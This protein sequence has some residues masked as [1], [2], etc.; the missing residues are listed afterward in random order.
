M[1]SSGIV[2]WRQLEAYKWGVV[3]LSWVTRTFDSKKC[4]LR[5]NCALYQKAEFLLGLP[6]SRDIWLYQRHQK[7]WAYSA[8]F[9]FPSQRKRQASTL[10][11]WTTAVFTLLKQSLPTISSLVIVSSKFWFQRTSWRPR[12]NLRCA[13]QR[14]RTRCLGQSDFFNGGLDSSLFWIFTLLS[15]KHFW[16]DFL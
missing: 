12:L 15:A 11:G 2:N 4:D 3:K 7:H 6:Q 14:Y 1:G 5:N 10:A 8:C 13:S 16:V 9:T